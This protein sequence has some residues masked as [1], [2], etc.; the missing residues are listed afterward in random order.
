MRKVLGVLHQFEG[1]D[2]L[3]DRCKRVCLVMER[4]V[5][6]AQLTINTAESNTAI[7]NP[8]MVRI[9]GSLSREDRLLSPHAVIVRPRPVKLFGSGT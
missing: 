7:P 6:V 3:A 1:V 2:R 4:V 8:M 9:C 5:A